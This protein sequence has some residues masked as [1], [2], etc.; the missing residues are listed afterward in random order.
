MTTHRPARS[1][2]ATCRASPS[3]SKRQWA[4]NVRGRGRSCPPSAKTPSIPMSPH[5]THRP[6]ANGRRSPKVRSRLMVEEPAKPVGLIEQQQ[7]AQEPLEA[8]PEQAGP[9]NVTAAKPDK[10]VRARRTLEATKADEARSAGNTR[11]VA[12]ARKTAEANEAAEA[13]AE[14]KKPKAKKSKTGRRPRKPSAKRR[15]RRAAKSKKASSATKGMQEGDCKDRGQE[16]KE[17]KLPSKPR[18]KSAATTPKKTKKKA[19]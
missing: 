6:C 2:S 1:G 10:K 17:E 3:W 18:R 19:R 4:P 14:A 8:T 16:S 15:P 11:K 13:K 9:G 5:A 12:A 7:P